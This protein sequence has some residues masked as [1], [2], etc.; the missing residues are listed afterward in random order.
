MIDRGERLGKTIGLFKSTYFDQTGYGGYTLKIRS[1]SDRIIQDKIQDVCLTLTAS[2]NIDI[3]SKIVIRREVELDPKTRLIYHDMETKFI[4]SLDNDNKIQA[5]NSAVL[6]GKLLQICNGAVYDDDR[7]I[8]IVSDDKLDELDQIIQDNPCENVL[9]AYNYKH[10]LARIKN[11]FND[12]VILDKTETVQKNWNEGK[13]KLLLAHPKSAAH[14]LNLQRGGSLIV[15][16]GLTW[17]LEDYLQFNARLHRQGQKNVVRILHLVVK[18]S[19]ED[20]ILDAVN[21]KAKTQDDLKNYLKR[22]IVRA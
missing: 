20:K 16:F 2:D 17:S 21:N 9:V 10:D 1:G 8:K 19:I 5:S 18:D 7:D 12:A 6:A 3:P 13:I 4:A 22:K 14:G 15:W 11:K